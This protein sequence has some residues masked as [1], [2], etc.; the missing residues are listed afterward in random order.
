MQKYKVLKKDNGDTAEYVL[1]GQGTIYLKPH[2]K[3]TE[4]IIVSNIRDEV[5]KRMTEFA[6]QTWQQI[7]RDTWFNGKLR[8]LAILSPGV[9]LPAYFMPIR[10]ANNVRRW[11]P[12][13]CCKIPQHTDD[14]PEL[15]QW[16]P[17]DTIKRLFLDKLKAQPDLTIPAELKTAH[18][19]L[20]LGVF[21]LMVFMGDKAFYCWI[22]P[23][24]T[25]KGV[26]GLQ[27]RHPPLPNLFNDSSV[28]LGS[29][30]VPPGFNVL[31]RFT[32]LRKQ[33]TNNPWANDLLPP[34][35]RS[36]AFWV[37]DQN[38]NW[39][40]PTKTRKESNKDP[41]V[42]GPV[43]SKSIR[44][45]N[46]SEILKPFHTCCPVAALAADLDVSADLARQMWVSALDW[47]IESEDE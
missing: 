22:V 36:A 16:E 28:C 47:R 30:G 23:E 19:T 41:L 29:E 14:Y 7:S 5:Q 26:W 37:F 20:P 35:E 32:A 2:G 33:L 17:M 24:E 40:L 42:F 25:T 45:A 31:D 38:M 34:V 18:L 6:S 4:P 27:F 44:S 8:A 21:E 11:V 12:N 15:W 46:M 10:T 9:T 13:F 39:V 43:Y 3:R 1:D